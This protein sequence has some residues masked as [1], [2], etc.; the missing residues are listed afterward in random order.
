MHKVLKYLIGLDLDKQKF[1]AL[2]C[3]YFVTHQF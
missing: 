1:W 3:E 2:N